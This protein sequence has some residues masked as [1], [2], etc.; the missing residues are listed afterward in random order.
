MVRRSYDVR[1]LT[2]DA[3]LIDRQVIVDLYMGFEKLLRFVGGLLYTSS[4]KAGRLTARRM[5][6]KGLLSREN[7][8][9]MLLWS[10][11]AAGYAERTVVERIEKGRGRTEITIRVEGALLGSRVGKRR[12]PVD[13]PLAGYLAG[14]LEE[15]Y[16]VRVDARETS[17][18]A[19]GDP[20]CRFEI[21][22]HGEIEPDVAEGETYERLQP[23]AEAGTTTVSAAVE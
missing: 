5:I 23:N 7:A 17:C 9:D 6:N 20:V 1:I 10:F 3:V 2:E 11:T 13:Q 22:V 8:I 21:K 4:K 19:K 18:I 14:W 12:R 15:V 16:G